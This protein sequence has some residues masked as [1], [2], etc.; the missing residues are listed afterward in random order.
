MGLPCSLCVCHQF[1][2][3]LTDFNGIIYE[4]Y[5]A[6]SEIKFVFFEF[7]Q[8]LRTDPGSDSSDTRDTNIQA[9]GRNDTWY[10]KA[11]PVTGREGP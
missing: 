2:K 11:I 5:A 6:G 10:S 9:G 4:I 1:L 8:S 7:L 3:Q